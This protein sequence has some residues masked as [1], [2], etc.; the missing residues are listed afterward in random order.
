MLPVHCT[1]MLPFHKAARDKAVKDAIKALAGEFEEG[2][3]DEIAQLRAS[4]QP[5]P[6]IEQVPAPLND[7]GT[8]RAR[9]SKRRLETISNARAVHQQFRQLRMPAQKKIQPLVRW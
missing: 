3:L 2:N 6:T 9:V 5:V 7:E 4:V 1:I 8:E